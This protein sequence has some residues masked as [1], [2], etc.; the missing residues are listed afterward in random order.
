MI[1]ILHLSSQKGRPPAPRPQVPRG[2]QHGPHYY[3]SSA[4]R[5]FASCKSLVSKPSVNQSQTGASNSYA[6]RRLPWLCHGRARLVSVRSSQDFAC[7]RR[8]QSSEAQNLG[9]VNDAFLPAGAQHRHFLDLAWLRHAQIGARFRPCSGEI[10]MRQ[11][12]A[13]ITIKKNDVA[14]FGLLLTQL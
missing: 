2:A 4:S 8:A 1:M 5:A 12:L 3:P 10:G 14:S 7:W 13:L 11:R 9:A 6:A